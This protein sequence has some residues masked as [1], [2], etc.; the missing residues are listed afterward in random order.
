MPDIIYRLVYF[1]KNR[2]TGGP[3]RI[4]T[5]IDSIL[6]ASRR[7]NP[8]CGITG[9]LVFNRGI[10]AQA[11]EGRGVAVET[12]FERIQQDPRHGDVQVLA[13]NKAAERVFPNWSM[14]FL[15]QSR[16]DQ[17]MFGHIGRDTGFSTARIEGQRLLEIIRTIAL[18]EEARAA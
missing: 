9:A 8:H 1:S 17:N 18:E 7:N 11:L 10:F 12:V 3:E 4:A 15:G 13:F 16:E 2:I 6:A 5:E 14:A